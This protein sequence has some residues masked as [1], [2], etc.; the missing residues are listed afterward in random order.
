MKDTIL[1][2]IK[3]QEP[4][5]LFT[6]KSEYVCAIYTTKKAL[7]LCS[8]ISQIFQTQLN[9][10]TLFSDNQSVITLVTDYQYHSHTKYINVYYHFI[11]WVVK[12]GQIQLIYCHTMDIVTNILMKTLS[13]PKVKYFA[14]AL[15]LGTAWGEV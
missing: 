4:V 1:W 14:S 8:L 11:C 12:E 5:T 2:S 13:S 7:W 3:K 10:T 15:D 9:I 6:T